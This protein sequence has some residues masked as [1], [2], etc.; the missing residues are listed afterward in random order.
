MNQTKISF[1]SFDWIDVQAPN[2]KGLAKLAVE[3]DIPEKI[4]L[5]AI[6]SEYLPKIDFFD[7]RKN[8]FI[9]FRVMDPKPKANADSISELTTKVILII[10]D[11]LVLTLHRQPL[12]F[13]DTIITDFKPQ[14]LTCQKPQLVSH[15]IMGISQT[16]D[17]P[18]LNLQTHLDS[19]DEKIFKGSKSK[20]ILSIGY[21]L[22]RHSLVF[23]KVLKFTLDNI[24][25]L[26]EKENYQ[27]KDSKDHV[28]RLLFYADDVFENVNSLMNMYISMTSQKTNEA[29]FKTNEVMRVL[30][31]LSLFF[32]PLNFIAG[33]YGMNFRNMPE[34]QTEHGYFYVLGA[35]GIL[36]V[37]LFSW[38]W[39]K[40]WLRA[41]E[42]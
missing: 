17:L 39:R 37:A 5:S 21:Y 22:K 40:G 34:L 14:T 16:F 26:Q 33:V 36:A 19:F 38:V 13:M 41:P 7:E 25:K 15:L 3:L 2:Q 27:L 18:L 28:E 35:M 31:V 24:V 10:K 32:L 20:R 11:N 42:E 29:S 9:V 4:L 6:D 12:V 23:R 30:T 1:S 8:V